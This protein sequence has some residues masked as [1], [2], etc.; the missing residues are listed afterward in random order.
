MIIMK[1]IEIIEGK[2]VTFEYSKTGL[3]KSIYID[4]IIIDVT[5]MT[6][7]QINNWTGG[8][9]LNGEFWIDIFRDCESYLTKDSRTKEVDSYH[10]INYDYEKALFA[11]L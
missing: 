7:E 8:N 5:K 4:D 9:K 6:P 2:P 3:L 1:N 11:F 10:G